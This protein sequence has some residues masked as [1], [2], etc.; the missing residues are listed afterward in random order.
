MKAVKIDVELQPCSYCKNEDVT[1]AATQ[2]DPIKYCVT[3]FNCNARGPEE[4]NTM[5]GI[6]RWN[7]R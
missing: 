7:K 2:Y 1:L 4:E 3:C 6:E 5:R